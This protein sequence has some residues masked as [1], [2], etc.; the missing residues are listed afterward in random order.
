MDE[1]RK[2]RSS[3]AYTLLS[4]LPILFLVFVYPRLP[5][6]EG[7]SLH[8]SDTV[9]KGKFS[10]EY[11]VAEWGMLFLIGAASVQIFRARSRY[12][13]AIKEEE[14]VQLDDSRSDS[15]ARPVVRSVPVHKE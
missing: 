13:Q 7:K 15:A 3:A 14:D 12:Y 5:Q 10:A 2:M 8:P 9:A 6:V 1:V 4:A 11:K